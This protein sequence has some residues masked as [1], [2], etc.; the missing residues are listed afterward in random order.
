MSALLTEAKTVS[1]KRASRTTK[2]LSANKSELPFV[3]DSRAKSSRFA[4]SVAFICPQ[5]MRQSLI[6]R[7]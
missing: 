5:Y 6:R 3:G 2:K 7:M 1:T 4:I